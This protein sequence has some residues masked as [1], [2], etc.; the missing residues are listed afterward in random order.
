MI[1]V[2]IAN[3]AGLAAITIL[4]A[5]YWSEK[6]ILSAFLNNMQPRSSESHFAMALDLAGVIHAQTPRGEDPPF[7]PIR[8]L[9]I[10]GATPVSI[11]RRGGCCS[12][13]S[14][15][16]IT[17][18]GTLGIKAAQVTLYHSAGQAQHCLA[19]VSLGEQRV[20]VDPSYGFYFVDIHGMPLA[21]HAL[22]QGARPQYRRLP[23]SSDEDYPANDYYNFA[24]S[25]TKTAN[26]TKTWIR[27]SAYTILKT[28]T[29]GRID[30]LR[31][32][33]WLEW[34]QVTLAAA[35]TVGILVFNLVML[36]QYG[37]A[38]VPLF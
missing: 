34:P 35:I 32:P 20:L 1:A 29:A 8:L 31:Q 27:R 37:S 23:H 2:L 26:W 36:F 16:Y 4:F 6:R 38:R 13:L 7:I 18:L 11:L 33:L 14:R 10:L 5:H 12:G 28:L 9:D 3:V 25:N 24:F 17:G 15:L 30:T 21:L 19:E 22:R